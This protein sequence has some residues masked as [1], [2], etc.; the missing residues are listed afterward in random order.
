MIKIG[1]LLIIAGWFASSVGPSFII[2]KVI[3]I[4]IWKVGG[5]FWYVLADGRIMAFGPTDLAV[6][7]RAVR[8]KMSHF[9]TFETPCVGHVVGVLLF[10]GNCWNWF[11]RKGSMVDDGWHGSMG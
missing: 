1:G 7:F 2:V 10:R 9:L 6:V 11:R 3:V 4:I 8:H 5:I